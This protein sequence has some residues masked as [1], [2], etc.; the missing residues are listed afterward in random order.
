MKLKRR[1]FAPGTAPVTPKSIKTKP[2]QFSQ[3]TREKINLYRMVLTSWGQKN[4]LP[5][6]GEKLIQ[7][8]ASELHFILQ[9]L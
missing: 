1:H 4:W 3:N 9:V 6:Y 7:I 8:T 2:P 5:L